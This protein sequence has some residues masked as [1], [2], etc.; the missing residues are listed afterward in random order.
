[1]LIGLKSI[2]YGGRCHCC[3]TGFAC[4]DVISQ[5]LELDGLLALGVL[6]Q[7][8]SGADNFA[9]VVV[10][11]AFDLVSDEDLKMGA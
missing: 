8:Q 10:A 7:L 5:R 11:A 1:V 9:D 4:G 3:A 2:K 6:E